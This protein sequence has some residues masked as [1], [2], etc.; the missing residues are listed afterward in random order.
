MHAHTQRYLRGSYWPVEMMGLLSV[1]YRLKVR[2]HAC[3]RV[4]CRVRC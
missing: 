2:T 4:C 3:M 1:D